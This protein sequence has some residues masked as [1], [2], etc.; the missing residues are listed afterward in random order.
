[1]GQEND[2]ILWWQALGMGTHWR[3]KAK[4]LQEEE[5]SRFYVCKC[6]L[7]NL[8]IILYTPVKKM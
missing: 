6:F 2:L 8:K 5:N 4:N 7:I 1:L 3:R